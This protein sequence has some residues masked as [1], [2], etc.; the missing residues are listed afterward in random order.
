[1][2]RLYIVKWIPIFISTDSLKG[3]WLKSIF[4]ILNASTTILL[5]L[6]LDWVT[7]FLIDLK[8]LILVQILRQTKLTKIFIGS[9]AY[10][11]FCIL[12]IL[13]DHVMLT[14]VFLVKLSYLWKLPIFLWNNLT[15]TLI[16]GRNFYRVFFV[17][18]KKLEVKNILNFIMLLF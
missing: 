1:V 17:G 4:F 2:W 8:V 6:I 12:I 13:Y 5:T 18:V 14:K 9:Y 7:I 16:F 3:R 10:E 15:L 11:I